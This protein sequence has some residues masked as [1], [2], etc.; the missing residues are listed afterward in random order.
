[1][2]AS[3][4][5]VLRLDD[6][7]RS[8]T[9]GNDD[10]QALRGVSISVERGEY[11]AVIGPSGSGKSTLMHIA[12]CLDRPTTG[13]CIVGGIRVE[14]LS[15]DDLSRLRN[16]K[17]GF[18]FQAFHLIPQLSVQ[19][20][21]EV[22][23]I[24]AGVEADRRAKLA[25][26]ML[27]RVG[28]GAR[29]AHRPNELSGGERQ[30]VAISRALVAKPELLFADEPTGNLD[31]RT[32]E[33][34]TGILEALRVEGVSIIVVT[35]NVALARRAERVL[36]MRDGRIERE[37]RGEERLRLYDGLEHKPGED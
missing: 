21:V 28:L 14:D 25:R 8:Y 37:L 33:E 13:H 15:D 29:L 11:L 32:G 6:V 19:E 7:T 23:L 9:V 36:Q 12:G 2:K 10:F 31:E 17:I 4:D 22:P 34:I 30:R 1:L 20:N 16:R 3:V 27:D 35:H 5:E 24:Y 26:E 18:V